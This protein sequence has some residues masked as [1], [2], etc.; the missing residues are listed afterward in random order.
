MPAPEGSDRFVRLD[1]S[2]PAAI[3][4]PSLRPFND[5][6]KINVLTAPADC[7]V[8]QVRIWPHPELNSLEI[9]KGG[10]PIGRHDAAKGAR[11]RVQGFLAACDPAA[12]R[13]AHTI[14]PDHHISLHGAAAVELKTDRVAL[15]DEIEESVPQMQ[16]GTAERVAKDAL[17]IGSMDAVIGCAKAVAVRRVPAHG[18]GRDATAVLPAPIDQLCRFR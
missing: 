12:N 11:P 17:E 2:L 16:P 15:I 7:V 9:W 3:A 6:E 8:Q 14:R 1:W 5:S 13:R 4:R 18:K 10:K